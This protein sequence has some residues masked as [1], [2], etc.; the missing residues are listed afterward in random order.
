M[1]KIKKIV[2]FSVM[3]KMIDKFRI[4]MD[5][6]IFWNRMIDN[7]INRISKYNINTLNDLL[8]IFLF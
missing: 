8:L 7:I 6:S 2:Y 1:C 4:M 5:L 3:N